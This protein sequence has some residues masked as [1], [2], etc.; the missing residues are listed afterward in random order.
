MLQ[1]ADLLLLDEPTND[2]DIPTLEILEESLLDFPGAMVLVTHDRYLLDRVAT[3]VLGLDGKGGAERFADYSQWN[4]WQIAR[5]PVKSS[6]VPAPKAAAVK[7]K[8][9][10]IEAR[11]YETIE[12]RV[13]E[14]EVALEAQHDAV[15]HAASKG[16][17]ELET[18]MEE[19]EK[20]QSAVDELYARWAEL[21]KKLG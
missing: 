5:K 18:A 17:K 7:K 19:L 9:S 12:H 21:E 14:A 13:T 1:P 2:L 6:N 16:G 4:E 10:Y 20:K 3:V 15:Q 8:L 11:D